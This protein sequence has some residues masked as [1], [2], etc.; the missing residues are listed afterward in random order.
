M[1][2]A[3]GIAQADQ[4][5]L[6]TLVGRYSEPH[7]AYHTLQHLDACFTHFAAVRHLATYPQEVELALWFHDA[8][9]L[10][11]DPDNEQKSADW[12]SSALLAAGGS[13]ISAQ[14]V[15]AMVMATGHGT[16]PQSNDEAILLDVDLAILGA[17]PQLFDA[18]EAQ[19]RQEYA[20]V[21]QTSFRSGRRRILQQFVAREQIYN[22]EYFSTR[23]E[24][25]ARANLQRSIA[26]LG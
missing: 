26:L 4:A 22:T 6:R 16:V 13:A 2:R 3:L 15:H 8:V 25:Q 11:R 18:Y 7:R 20:S 1:W 9:Y 10:V 23:Y 21:P 5:L 17:T 19:V 24:T 12:A 14:R